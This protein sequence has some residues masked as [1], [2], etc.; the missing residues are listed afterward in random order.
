[1]LLWLLLIFAVVVVV[2][3]A[4]IVVVYLAI[5]I[6]ELV[7]QPV[8]SLIETVAAGCTRRLYIPIAISEWMQA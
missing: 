2:V 7:R 6:L 3:S 4:A 8:K 1:M 5:S